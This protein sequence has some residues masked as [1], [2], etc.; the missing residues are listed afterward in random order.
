MIRRKI[1]LVFQLLWVSDFRANN[2]ILPRCNLSDF[3]TS[4]AHEPYL[5]STNETTITGYFSLFSYAPG[6][7]AEVAIGFQGPENGVL[8]AKEAILIG[9]ASFFSNMNYYSITILAWNDL[10]SVL[11]V[12]TYTAVERSVRSSISWLAR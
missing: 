12:T 4:V 10:D 2:I 5:I 11:T 8:E 1:G 3:M 9:M 7:E 6:G